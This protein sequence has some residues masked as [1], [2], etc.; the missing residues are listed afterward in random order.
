MFAIGTGQCFWLASLRA[1][2][3]ESQK[4]R[5]RLTHQAVWHM[6]KQRQWTCKGCQSV[7]LYTGAP[8]S[9]CA[10][11]GKAQPVPLANPGKGNVPQPQTKG[12]G[13]G[14]GAQS[15]S[16]PPS[17]I[18]KLAG[19]FAGQKWQSA[20]QHQLQEQ[21]RVFLATVADL[22]K[23]MEELKN[24][25]L[26]KDTATAQAGPTANKQEQNP[27]MPPPMSDSL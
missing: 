4:A 23:T 5:A 25:V 1:H 27:I 11:C 2:S 20:P 12:K 13:K 21:Q 19:K 8:P 9:F 6:P 14:K 18:H 15:T 7:T 22:K 24:P 17:L 3:S 26:H 10:S 16:L